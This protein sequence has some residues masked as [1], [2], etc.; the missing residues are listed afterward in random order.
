[1]NKVKIFLCFQ[2]KYKFVVI[3]VSQHIEMMA[4]VLTRYL[5]NV[6]A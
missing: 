6:A 1:M 2:Y 5:K 3:E 4:G